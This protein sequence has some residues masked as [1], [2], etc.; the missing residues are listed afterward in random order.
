[1]NSFILKKETS[2]FSKWSSVYR[3]LAS[4]GAVHFISAN[5]PL[6]MP[7]LGFR[8]SLAKNTCCVVPLSEPLNPPE[9]AGHTNSTRPHRSRTPFVQCQCQHLS[10]CYRTHTN[11]YR[12]QK[13]CD[14]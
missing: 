9:Y 14:S 10:W 8:Y 7:K 11:I 6:F 1:M 4:L 3:L 13:Q 12:V 2:A 5:R